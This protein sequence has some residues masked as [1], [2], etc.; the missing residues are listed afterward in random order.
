VNVELSDR[1]HQE[2]QR[3]NAA[4][5]KQ[6]DFPELFLDELLETVT[7]IETTGMLGTPY[8]VKAKRR[9]TRLLMEKCDTPVR[10]VPPPARRRP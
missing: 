8:Q 5:R 4:W 6:A 7:L 3:I 2:M 1:A 10:L 9:V